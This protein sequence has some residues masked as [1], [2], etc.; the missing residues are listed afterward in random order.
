MNRENK[1]RK[2]EKGYTARTVC[3][4]SMR[5]SSSETGSQTAAY[6]WTGSSMLR[7]GKISRCLMDM[8]TR[9]MVH[10]EKEKPDRR[11]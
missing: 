6:A 5:I 1:R 9:K 10:C 3:P 11:K 4:A 8:E 2:Y 7:S